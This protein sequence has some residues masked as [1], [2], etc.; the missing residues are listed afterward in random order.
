MQC[1]SL[2]IVISIAVLSFFY[3]G[4]DST[5]MRKE[6]FGGRRKFTSHISSSSGPVTTTRKS[7][8]ILWGQYPLMISILMRCGSNFLF[9]VNSV[10]VSMVVNIVRLAWP[11]K[12]SLSFTLFLQYRMFTFPIYFSHLSILNTKISQSNSKQQIIISSSWKI[13]IVFW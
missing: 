8:K 11:S 13:D 5:K 9:S 2:Y 1:V 10:D 4:R 6:E 12:I 3:G 7:V